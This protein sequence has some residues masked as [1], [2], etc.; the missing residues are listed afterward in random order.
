MVKDDVFKRISLSSA[1]TLLHKSTHLPTCN[2]WHH[3]F[4]DVLYYFTFFL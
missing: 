3:P 4:F 1:L 2:F